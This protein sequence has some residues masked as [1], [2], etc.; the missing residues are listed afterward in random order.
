MRSMRGSLAPILYALVVVLTELDDLL[1]R[2]RVAA[3]GNP[4]VTTIVFP[5]PLLFAQ[6]ASR[7]PPSM[8]TW[9]SSGSPLLKADV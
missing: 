6:A 7:Q 5:L 2:S 4:C 1:Q 8:E 3:M 9:T